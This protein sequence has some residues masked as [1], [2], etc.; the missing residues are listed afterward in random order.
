FASVF[1]QT[2][3]AEEKF[4]KVQI[5]TPAG[6]EVTETSV[7]L[8]FLDDEMQIESVSDGKTIKTFKYS[9]IKDAEYSYSK[10]PRWK[11]GLGLGVASIAFL[12]LLFVAIPVG[13][14]KHRRHWLTI[15]TENDYAVLKL[16]KINRK[17]LI[18]AFETRTR[19]AVK[20]NGE[21]K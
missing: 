3:K 11:T 17:L 7:R 8:R 13:L 2:S 12:P 9:A 20:G 19:I 18:P 14:T 16:S 21:S 6:Q 5:L 1:A 4:E 15:K 10:S